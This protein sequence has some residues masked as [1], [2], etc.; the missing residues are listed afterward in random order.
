MRGETGWGRKK[1]RKR[2]VKEGANRDRRA[3][4]KATRGKW[5]RPPEREGPGHVA[6]GNSLLLSAAGFGVRGGEESAGGGDSGGIVVVDVGQ[7]R[8][9]GTH[10]ARPIGLAIGVHGVV[11]GGLLV[12]RGRVGLLRPQLLVGRLGLVDGLA[13]GL[14]AGSGVGGGGFGGVGAGGIAG[15]GVG[16]A[17]AGVAG[18]LLLL[19]SGVMLGLLPV[20]LGLPRPLP[21]PLPTSV[22]V[23]LGR[24]AVTAVPALTWHVHDDGH[25]AEQDLVRGEIGNSLLAPDG[26][27]PLVTQPPIGSDHR[28]QEDEFAERREQAGEFSQNA[29][30]VPIR[31]PLKRQADEVGRLRGGRVEEGAI[32]SQRLVAVMKDGFGRGESQGERLLRREKLE[33]QNQFT[34]DREGGGQDGLRSERG[35]AE[36]HVQRVGG[37]GWRGGTLHGSVVL[38][39]KLGRAAAQGRAREG[40]SAGTRA[41]RWNARRGSLSEGAL[42]RI[43]GSGPRRRPLARTA[44][45]A[46]SST[47]SGAGRVRASAL[48]AGAPEQLSRT[49]ANSLHYERLWRSKNEKTTKK[50]ETSTRRNGRARRARKS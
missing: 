17:G 49:G 45:A 25:P 6:T 29:S 43:Q 11:K 5:K 14:L 38:M 41:L 47:A 40:R 35:L 1:T 21:L 37:G 13:V 23:V 16:V 44:S 10:L 24:G 18:L 31:N 30:T 9:G 2:A 46:S 4:K 12:L 22:L 48:G 32:L 33:A 50:D 36:V 7:D 42:L 34:E 28:R 15:A 26:R 3:Q 27:M 19:D 8:L 39:L 20:S